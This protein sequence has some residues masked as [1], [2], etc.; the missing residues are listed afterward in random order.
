MRKRGSGG[1]GSDAGVIFRVDHQATSVG[2][3]T[4]PMAYG[5]SLASLLNLTVDTDNLG[6]EGGGNTWNWAHVGDGSGWNGRNYI[7]YTRWEDV[8]A[9]PNAGFF[10]DAATP[11]PAGGW[12]AKATAG[13]LYLRFR[14]RVVQSLTL[15]PTNPS[16]QMKFFLFGGPGISGERRMILFF[17]RATDATYGSGTDDD[18]EMT[19]RVGAG[20]SGNHA[21][22]TVPVGEWVH[23]QVSWRYTDA[24]SPYMRVYINNNTEGAPDAEHTTFTADSMGG[25]WSA[26]ESWTTGHWHDLA[27]SNSYTGTDFIADLMDFELGDAFNASWAP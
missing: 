6:T 8:D 4:Y 17:E 10:W 25:V 20:V 1:G 3:T 12:V 7:R 16:A 21:E 13:P 15:S 14:I 22:A 18:T 27:S 23:V 26:I 24:G 11:A 2:G 5:A 9:A 19:V